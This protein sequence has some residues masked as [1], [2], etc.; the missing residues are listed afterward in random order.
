[1]K[2]F[3]SLS[4]VIVFALITLWLQNAFKDSPLITAQ[5]QKH[6]PDYFMDGFSVQ[7]MDKNGVPAYE[8]H[9]VKLQHYSD[10][11]SSEVTLPRIEI[12]DQRGNWSVVA[13]RAVVYGDTDIIHLYDQVKIRRESTPQQTALLIETSYLKIDPH[14]KL[15]ETDQP[16]HISTDAL[17]L[18]SLGM[19]FDGKRDILKLTSNVRGT[20]APV[21]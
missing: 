2:A 5:K 9:A 17:E 10:S 12:H 4:I 6:F 18:N 1:M 21:K 3:I 15:A 8:L 20:H 16:A 11:D 7:Q 13:E 19:A 14:K